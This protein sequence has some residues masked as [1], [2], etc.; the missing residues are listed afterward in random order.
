MNLTRCEFNHYYDAD[1]YSE[2]PHCKKEAAISKNEK[3]NGGEIAKDEEKSL[4]I[5]EKDD[6]NFS[7]FG[8]ETE[9]EK[10]EEK[11]STDYNETKVPVEDMG[12]TIS[13]YDYNPVVGW[14]VAID[15]VH[16]G[17]SFTL[18][19][20]TNYIGRN[21][22]MDIC[23]IKDSHVSRNRHVSVIYD[24]KNVEFVVYMGESKELVHINDELLLNPQKLK[25][26]DLISVG[27][28]VLMFVAFCNKEF[29]W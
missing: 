11:E 28:T 6:W 20:G 4:P 7:L 15:G 24:A 12:K 27:K 29:S 3:S 16:K 26:R 22:N 23:L 9:T 5:S 14:L 19:E 13:A 18:K 21:P 10:K 17:D 8:E 2:C 25:D 1:K